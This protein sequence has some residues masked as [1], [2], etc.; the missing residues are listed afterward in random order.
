MLIRPQLY[1]DLDGVLAD[2]YAHYKALFGVEVTHETMDKNLIRN[3]P[4]GF[5]LQLPEMPDA[6]ELWNGVLDLGLKPI[7]LTAAGPDAFKDGVAQQKL[8]WV[9]LHFGG[10]FKVIVTRAA[11]KWTYANHGDVLVDD[12]PRYKANWELWAGGRFILHTSAKSS[13]EQLREVYHV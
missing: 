3:H 10:E 13:L 5:F 6:R 1:L 11:K 4:G 8:D 12:Y 2:F 7:V 9:R